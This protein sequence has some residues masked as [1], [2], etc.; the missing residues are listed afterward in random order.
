[1]RSCASFMGIEISTRSSAVSRRLHAPALLSGVSPEQGL[2]E[3]LVA[4]VHEVCVSSTAPDLAKP[5]AAFS[6][7]RHPEDSFCVS[8]IVGYFEL[9][10]ALF[11]M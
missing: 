2:V 5:P 6:V 1:M 10:Q 3:N 7:G 11:A 9:N 8:I 4:I